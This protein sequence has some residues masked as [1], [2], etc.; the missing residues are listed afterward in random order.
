MY[1]SKRLHIRNS[2]KSNN[3]VSKKRIIQSNN[4]VSKKRIVQIQKWNYIISF[5]KNVLCNHYISTLQNKN[6][7]NK[8]TKTRSKKIENIWFFRILIDLIFW[9]NL[10]KSKK[11]E[12]ALFASMHIFFIVFS[13][14]FCLFHIF[15]IFYEISKIK[16][17]KYRFINI[18]KNI[19]K[20]WNS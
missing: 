13:I 20:F 5:R 7:I 17:H 14:I 12:F 3:I 11:F 10:I 15:D 16:L 4:T 2:M 19:W 8:K 6:L 9:Q 18:A 1:W